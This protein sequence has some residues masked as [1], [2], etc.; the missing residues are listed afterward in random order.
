MKWVSFGLIG[1]FS[2]FVKFMNALNIDVAGAP[3][4]RF[5]LCLARIDDLL[6]LWS[7]FL[8][9]RKIWKGFF[10]KMKIFFLITKF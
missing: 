6:D 1:F 9:V 2:T 10:T 4:L 8:S 7:Y 3:D 5:W